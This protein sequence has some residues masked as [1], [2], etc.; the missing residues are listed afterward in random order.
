M[1]LHE[2][3]IDAAHKL[4]KKKEI[5]SRELTRAVFDRIDAVESKIDAYIT[6][7]EE[8]ALQQ[9]A[10]ADKAI[11]NGECSPLTGIPLGIKDLICTRNIPTT[12]GSKIL[13]RFYPAL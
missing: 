4:L 12:C 6:L 7:C 13:E 2:L 9:A 11:A 1:K 5:S 3:T 10:Q 8:F